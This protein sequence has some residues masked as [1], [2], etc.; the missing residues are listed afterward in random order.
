MNFISI[1][2]NN[3]FK[4]IYLKGKSFV[5]S[6]FVLYYVNNNNCENRIGLTVSKK[7]GNSVIR[8]KV[9]RKLKE[10]YRLSFDNLNGYFD[11]VIVGRTFAINADFRL[12]K[13]DMD[14]ILNKIGLKSEKNINSNSKILSKKNITIKKT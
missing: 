10:A 14:Q 9:R 13:K 5:R 6:T 3:E 11:I 8:N 2:K 4:Y 1:K 7:I 12:I